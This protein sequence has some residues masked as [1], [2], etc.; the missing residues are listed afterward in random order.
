MARGIRKVE[1]TGM[2]DTIYTKMAKILAEFPTV[3]KDR[4]NPSQKYSYRG[5]DD[6]LSAL[7]PLLAKHGVFMQMVSMDAVFSPAGETSSGKQQVRCVLRGR[8]AFVHGESKTSLESEMVGEGIDMGDKAT[9]KAQANALKYLIWYTFAVP[10]EEPVDSEAHEDAPA[11]R[12]KLAPVTNTIDKGQKL[13]LALILSLIEGADTLDKLEKV[14]DSAREFVLVMRNG[15]PEEQQEAIRVTN[16][17][18]AK[19]ESLSK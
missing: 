1:D 4:V 17:I 11:Q 9:M 15:S 5:V 7:H 16:A 18:R 6:A 3:S 12:P 10:T 2:S 8:V 14:K 19:Q 13:S